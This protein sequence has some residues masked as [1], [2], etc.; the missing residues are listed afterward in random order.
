M[1]IAI[2]DRDK[3]IRERCGYLCQKYCP[4]VR[5][6]D[7]TITVDDETRYPVI[8]EILCTGCGICVKKCPTEAI[9]IINLVEEMGNPI[10]QYGVNSFRLYGIPIPAKDGV[11]GFVGKNG[12][13]KTTALKILSGRIIPNFGDYD[14]EYTWKEVIPRLRVEQQMYF[15]QFIKGSI[16]LSYKPQHVDIL[17][18]VFKGTVRELIESIHPARK[19]PNTVI[20]RFR[21]NKIEGRKLDNLSGGELQRVAIAAAWSKEADVY[22]FDEPTSYLDIE[23]RLLISRLIKSLSDDGKQVVVVEHDLAILDYL[24]DYVYI[25][26]GKEDAYGV[27]SHLRNARNG[28]NEYLTG[29]LKTENIRFREFEIK[30]NKS[31]ESRELSEEIILEYPKL[32]K[33]FP[34]FS[35]EVEPGKIHKGEIIGIIGKNAI[36]KSLF[37]KMIAG[38]IKPDNIDYEAG[39]KVSYKPQY[40]QIEQDMPVSEFFNTLDKDEFVFN[41]AV[42]RMNIE[43]L[44]NRML[45]ELSGGELQRVAIVGAL[46]Q[47]A[48]LYLFDEPSAFLDIEQRMHFAHLVRNVSDERSMFIVDHDIVLIDLVS[49]HLVV[50]DGESS[51]HG[52]AYPPVSKREGMNT[53]L[54]NLGITMRRDKDTLRPKINKP[55]SVLDR[56]QKETGEYYY[57]F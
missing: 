7:E 55:N 53:F 36:G 9:T 12:I 27:V 51:V 5:M 48:D 52:H 1:R 43:V 44:M 32:T 42:R 14:K 16:K 30:F 34:N 20:D 47:K 6:G 57:S 28:I 41:E 31:A 24:S 40:I 3:C 37:V 10:Y 26:Y 23:E 50:F 15:K 49:D 46:A 56:K 21:L 22:Y 8:S 39:L 18:K 45:S 29:Y 4:G 11:T 2:I 19:D 13:G 25:F 33:R 17:P 35:M 54:K 38:I